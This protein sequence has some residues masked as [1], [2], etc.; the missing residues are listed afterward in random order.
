MAGFEF[1]FSGPIAKKYGTNEAVILYNFAF[2][3]KRNSANQRNVRD[4]RVWTYNSQRAL[5]EIFDFLS[6][7][8]IQRILK[9]LEDSGAIIK[10]NFNAKKMD[11]TCWYSVSDEVME[12][13]GITPPPVGMESEE[14]DAPANLV[15]CKTPNGG[16]DTT[17]SDDAVSD[18][19]SPIPDNKPDN[20]PDNTLSGEF[21]DRVQAER[22]ELFWMR[23]PRKD[24]RKETIRVWKRLKPDRALFQRIMTAL[25][26]FRVS[27]QWN[28]VRG[29]WRKE[30]IPLPTSW[31]NA[32]RWNDES[33]RPARNAPDGPGG[34][35]RIEPGE[36]Y[37]YV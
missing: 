6:E 12:F 19:V 29:K 16:M 4:G 14:M 26:L 27:P 20:K 13:Y 17:E 32:E 24:K 11:R 25:D 34:P 8:Q 37:R 15:E 1:R 22:F 3:I 18:L 5:S 35:E 2:W 23:Y 33:V 31:L 10:G 21:A 7:R 28:D 9:K 30:Y 36:G